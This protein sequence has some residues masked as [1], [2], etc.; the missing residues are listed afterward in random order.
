MTADTQSALH[1]CA[2]EE[3][4]RGDKALNAVYQKLLIAARKERGAVEKIRI[5][6]PMDADLIYAYLTKKQTEA[7][8]VLLDHYTEEH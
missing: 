3:V 6:F 2:N 1:A 7:L 5:A 8:T 4:K